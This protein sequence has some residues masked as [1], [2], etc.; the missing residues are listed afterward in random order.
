MFIKKRKNIILFSV[1]VHIPGTL[2]HEIVKTHVVV[3]NRRVVL[4][5][6]ITH[7]MRTTN[8]LYF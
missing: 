3:I 7:I 8:C 4:S 6:T 5:P 2:E 1:K